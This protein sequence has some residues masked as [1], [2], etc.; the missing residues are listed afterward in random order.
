[1]AGLNLTY[2]A[3]ANFRYVYLW[4]LLASLVI[5]VTIARVLLP[6]TP[7]RTT[8]NAARFPGPVA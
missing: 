6:A 2:S 5:G 4:N 7:Q 3:A 1:M 8:V